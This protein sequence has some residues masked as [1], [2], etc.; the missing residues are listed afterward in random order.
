MTFSCKADND[1]FR[2]IP[3]A[4]RVD[5]P[6]EAIEK[7]PQDSAVLILADGY[8][9]SRVE[10]PSRLYERAK[11][12]H[13]R[14]YVEFPAA[15][16]GLSLGETK[17]TTWERGVVASDFFGDLPRLRIV[18][19]HD[20]H[21]SPVKVD[22]PTHLV[23]ARVA[24]YDTAVYGIPKSAQPL[25]FEMNDGQWLIATTKLSGFVTARFMP[26]AEWKII[27]RTILKKLDPSHEPPSLDFVPLARPALSA[28][29]PI[30]PQ[31]EHD[32]LTR[33][34][35]WYLRSRL[36][37]TPQRQ[38]EIHRLLKAGT[39]TTDAPADDANG[40]GSLGMLEGYASQIRFDGSQ[41]QRTPIRSDCNAEAA[42]VLALAGSDRGKKVASNLLDYTFGPEMES[43]GRSDPKHPAFGLIAWGAI[44]RAWMVGNYGDDDARVIL[45]TILASSALK[46]SRWDEQVLRALLSNLRTT[47]KLGFR[48]DRVD[49]GP[50]EQHG[51]KHFHDAE[52]IN[53]SPHFEGFLWMCYLWAYARTGE[54]EF[55]DKSISA[56][57]MTMDAYAKKQWRWM[58]NMER[59]HMLWCL[60]WLVRV[61]DS[62]EHRGWLMTVANDLL[63][64]QQ[65][66]GAI[67][68]RLGGT[69]GGHYQIPQSNEAY[70][71]G[72][73]PLIQ[74]VGDPATDQLYATGFSLI[75]LHEA[76]GATGDAKLKAAEDKLAEYL[77]RIQV[78]SEKIPYLD[79]A[80]FRAFDY[81]RWDYWAS[82]A[83]M[84]WGVWS[85]EAGWGQAWIAATLALREK[86][87]TLWDATA[88]SRVKTHL[89][90]VHA[91]LSQN[92][93]GPLSGPLPP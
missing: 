75:A 5:T 62:P 7:A 81:Q 76:V 86:K 15:V 65:P 63:D 51:W 92:T 30:P 21:Y 19:P 68:E 69:G 29:A 31:F 8:P 59:A 40:D 22:S 46:T 1:L 45:S 33:A 3:G 79:G 84:G 32:T 93:G 91:D 66:C 20:C 35:E 52:S 16:P 41:P 42:M 50:L 57:R 2:L 10:M 28:D 18:A 83:D 17:T 39:E 71:T 44:S 11:Q 77:C 89:E 78:R 49:I 6:A 73:T 38:P 56:I 74:K 61:Q 47:G 67:Q 9:K 36:L 24:G 4:K 87:T 70:G 88:D 23:I 48:G 43:M 54:R 85:V 12:K 82:S 26:T 34:A 58:D 72:E 64:A 25:L 27:W 90:K 80:W 13:L 14:L 53:F 37:I 60:A 55:L